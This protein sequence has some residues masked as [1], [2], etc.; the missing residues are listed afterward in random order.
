MVLVDPSEAAQVI[1]DVS[2][3]LADA[4]SNA[5]VFDLS[6]GHA[7]WTIRGGDHLEA[8]RRLCAIP[9]PP[10]PTCLQ[11]LFAHVPAKLVLTVD[12]ALVLVSAAVG[13]YVRERIRLACGDLELRDTA[14]A[15]FATETVERAV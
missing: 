14:R 12:S 5:V 6:D 15:P 3:Q 7:A 10:A 9:P 4:D 1:E 2:S 8:F 11:G 13:E